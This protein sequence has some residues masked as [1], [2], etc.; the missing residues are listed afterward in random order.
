[1]RGRRSCV[2]RL[3]QSPR[4]TRRL[5]IAAAVSAVAL[6]GAAC[7]GSAAT[8][9]GG[10]GGTAIVGPMTNAQIRGAAEAIKTGG[11]TSLQ[12]IQDL[13]R[14]R[15]SGLN[16]AVILS[17]AS[18]ITPAPPPPPTTTVAPTTTVPPTTTTTTTA[19]P[20]TLLSQSGD[21]LFTTDSFQPA[22]TGM[23]L[24][25]SYDCSG[26][27]S[28]GGNFIVS[29]LDSNG[30]ALPI[31]NDIGPGRSDTTHFGIASYA[32][33]YRLQINSECTW[34]VSVTTP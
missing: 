34:N 10:A 20:Q 6:L 22:V 26:F 30:Q 28:T 32:A 27:S 7:G 21:G 19:A 15:A 17:A 9:D 33:P 14:A 13:A 5:Q 16:D 23:T 11:I 18:A 8:N 12:N 25:W 24:H 29:V 2:A 1:M 3:T 4:L 31:V